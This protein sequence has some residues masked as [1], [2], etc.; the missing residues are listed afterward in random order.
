MNIRTFRLYTFIQNGR[1]CDSC[2][3]DLDFARCGVADVSIIRPRCYIANLTVQ[4]V[5]VPVI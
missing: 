2:I 5:R 3:K 1:P 4:F